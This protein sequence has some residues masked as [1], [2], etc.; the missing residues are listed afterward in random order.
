MGIFE[1]KAL[2][3]CGVGGDCYFSIQW[4]VVFCENVILYV[5]VLLKKCSSVGILCSDGILW[6]VWV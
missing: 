3:F 1:D 5:V 2:Y 6:V 4:V